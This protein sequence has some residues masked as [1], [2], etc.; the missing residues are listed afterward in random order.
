MALK[1]TDVVSGLPKKG[2]RRV[3]RKKHIGFTHVDKDGIKTG[4]STLVSRGTSYGTIGDDLVTR[5]ARQ[6][7]LSK[8]DFLRLVDCTLSADDYTKKL[9]DPSDSSA[10]PNGGSKEPGI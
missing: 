1:R 7:N 9:Q 8:S 10:H 2:F 4:V 5:M 3:L 6:C